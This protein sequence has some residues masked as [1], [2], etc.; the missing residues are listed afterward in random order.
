ME[1]SAEHP[2]PTT[3]VP[4]S[5]I[6]FSDAVATGGVPAPAAPRGRH[7]IPQTPDHSTAAADPGGQAPAWKPLAPRKMQHVSFELARATGLCPFLQ[8][9]VLQAALD[10]ALGR[11]R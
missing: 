3:D 10:L 6:G 4:D 11:Q 9:D 5:N 2:V 8:T 1:R 7:E